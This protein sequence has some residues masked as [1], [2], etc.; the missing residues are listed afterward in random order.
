MG[1]SGQIKRGYIGSYLGNVIKRGEEE[2]HH[3]YA[4]AQISMYFA[5][6]RLRPEPR[7]NVPRHEGKRGRGINGEDTG[8][9][10]WNAWLGRRTGNGSTKLRGKVPFLKGKGKG[11]RRREKKKR[12]FG[13]EI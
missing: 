4:K 7:G 8:Q 2:V 1:D 10:L 5:S 13:I 9:R 6:D 12:I 11:R 3:F